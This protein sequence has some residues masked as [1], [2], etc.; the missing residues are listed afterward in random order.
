MDCTFSTAV[1]WKIHLTTS[2][3]V[4]GG[5]LIIT[6]SGRKGGGFP[7]RGRKD[8]TTPLRSWNGLRDDEGFTIP[9][10]LVQEWGAFISYV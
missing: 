9:Y 8:T 4:A 3:E 7:P 5:T 6:T 1:K 10:Q 2:K